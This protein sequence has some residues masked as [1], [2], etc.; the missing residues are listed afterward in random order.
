LNEEQQA[1]EEML[2]ACVLDGEYLSEKGKDQHFMLEI[3]WNG[4]AILQS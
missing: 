2:L 3:E 4:K 1:E